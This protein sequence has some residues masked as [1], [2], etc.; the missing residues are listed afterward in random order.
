MRLNTNYIINCMW[1]KLLIDSQCIGLPIEA[2]EKQV[3]PEYMF[4]FISITF[5]SIQSLI[6]GKKLSILGKMPRLNFRCELS[7]FFE[8][9]Q[10][11]SLEVYAFVNE[12]KAIFTL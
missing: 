6:F 12:S 10:S 4:V 9:N 2:L 3:M 8:F 5:I 7:F 1:D 11:T